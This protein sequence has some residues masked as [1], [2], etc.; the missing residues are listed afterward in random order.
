MDNLTPRNVLMV[1]ASSQ[2]L[3]GLGMIA[4]GFGYKAADPG[5]VAIANYGMKS[6]SFDFDPLNLFKFIG[7]CKVLGTL[8]LWEVFGK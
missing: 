4:T 2:L 7:L 1:V 8:A 5:L 3:I 6:A